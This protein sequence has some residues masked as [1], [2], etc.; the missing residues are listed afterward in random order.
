MLHGKRE[1]GQ[2]KHMLQQL[3][4]DDNNISEAERQQ[5]RGQIKELQLFF[6]AL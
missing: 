5:L 1:E 6:I 3:G 2:F 4:V